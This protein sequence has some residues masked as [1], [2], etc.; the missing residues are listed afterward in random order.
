MSYFPKGHQFSA[1]EVDDFDEFDSTP[2]GGG[3]DIAL[4]YGRPLDHSDEICYPNTSSNSDD[5]DYDRPQ[6]TSS[7]EPSAYDDEALENE[8]KSYDRP[9]ARPGFQPGSARPGGGGEYG[10]G[11]GS[12]YRGRPERKQE[13]SEYGSGYEEPKPAYGSGY[14]RKSEYAEPEAEYEEPKPEYGSGYGRKPESEEYGS[15]YGRKSEYEE[16]KPEYGS[17]Y[18]RKSESEEYGSGYGRKSEYEEPKPEY[19]SGYGR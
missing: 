5:F 4:T 7:A 14:G 19:G 11:G 10:S 15:G 13:E 3:Y 17:G 18:G 1:E 16:P 9:K 12:G 6:F 2:Y 8:Y